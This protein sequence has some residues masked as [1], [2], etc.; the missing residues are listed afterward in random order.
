MSEKRKKAPRKSSDDSRKKW[1]CASMSREKRKERI[2][3]RALNFDGRIVFEKSFGCNRWF[4]DL[5]PIVRENEFRRERRIVKIL[6][7]RYDQ[8]GT[9]LHDIKHDYSPE[10]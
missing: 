8:L 5:H 1:A 9:L 4:E 2:Y 6:M 7:K 3:I 10:T